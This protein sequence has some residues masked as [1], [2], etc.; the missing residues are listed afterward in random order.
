VGRGK[1]RVC[2]AG[3]DH[4]AARSFLERASWRGSDAGGWGQRSGEERGRTPQLRAGGHVLNPGQSRGLEMGPAAR[5]E[6][7]GFAV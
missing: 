6:C 7:C 1:K 3:Q 5:K 4:A 2:A